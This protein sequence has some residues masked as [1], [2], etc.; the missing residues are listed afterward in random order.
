MLAS[1]TRGRY[2]PRQ[3]GSGRRGSWRGSRGEGSHYNG[4]DLGA[5]QAV[6]VKVLIRVSV[7][8][9]QLGAVRHLQNT[10][11]HLQEGGTQ[12]V[13]IGIIIINVARDKMKLR[14]LQRV[15]RFCFLKFIFPVENIVNR[16]Q[17][18]LK[19]DSGTKLM[20]PR[21]SV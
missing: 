5:G 19:K 10:V 6:G 21:G 18:D 1:A 11:H 9:Q 2:P 16:H 13:F 15:G 7:H 12:G 4:Q 20:K 17:Q 14:M 3:R 8:H